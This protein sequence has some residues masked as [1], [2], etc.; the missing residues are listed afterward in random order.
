VWLDTQQPRDVTI[1][2]VERKDIERTAAPK[3]SES[4][5]E[6]CPHLFVSPMQNDSPAQPGT[7]PR[8]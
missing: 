5:R 2:Y 7:D 3:E 6:A 4:L 8:E 1:L